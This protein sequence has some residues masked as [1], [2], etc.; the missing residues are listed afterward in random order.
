[1]SFHLGLWYS[2]G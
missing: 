1:V 2:T